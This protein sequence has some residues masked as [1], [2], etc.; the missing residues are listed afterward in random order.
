VT[1]VTGSSKITDTVQSATGATFEL[2][3]GSS[4][5]VSVTVR[6]V[7][8]IGPGSTRDVTLTVSSVNHPGVKPDVVKVSTVIA[9]IDCAPQ[10]VAFDNIKLSGN[11]VLTTDLGYVSNQPM[12]VNGL[13]FTFPAGA[14]GIVYKS[15]AWVIPK[16]ATQ[17]VPW[18]RSAH[19]VMSFKDATLYDGP[20]DM[21]MGG[22]GSTTLAALG[23]KGSLNGLSIE[24][25]AKLLVAFPPDKAG[26]VSLELPLLPPPLFA[27][28]NSAPQVITTDADGGGSVPLTMTWPQL[29]YSTIGMVDFKATYDPA[30][31][32]WTGFGR[33]GFPGG[34]YF[35][36][37]TAVMKF[38]GSSEGYQL[39]YLFG[40][41]S[42]GSAEPQVAPL[43]TLKQLEAMYDQANGVFYG[44]A[45]F[46]ALPI[47]SALNA[48]PGSKLASL[49]GT[50]FG[51]DGKFAYLDGPHT[52]TLQG[53][54]SLLGLL[55]LGDASFTAGPTGM[56]ATG[57]LNYTLDL[58]PLGVA[59]LTGRVDGGISYSSGFQIQGTGNVVIGGANVGSLSLILSNKGA[60]G[61]GSV[62]GAAA[63][64][65]FNWGS[66]PTIF[67]S[68]DLSPWQ[69]DGI[70]AHA[71]F[72]AIQGQISAMLNKV[73]DVQ[74]LMGAL[75]GAVKQQLGL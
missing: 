7:G 42:F 69:V 19:T 74:R 70:P 25:G 56:R 43:I 4:A 5:D 23:A 31:D 28:R 8:Q 24:P 13:H 59:G 9:Q 58:G 16:Y 22:S 46:N 15:Q 44:K 33:M 20:L 67:G 54:V 37:I 57:N 10:T 48:E 38:T 49:P 41:L 45:S 63:G 64:F 2:A 1:L 11:C 73:D 39:T 6:P 30:T 61:C 75:P 21:R 51:L 18:F 72:S 60:A 3:P 62:F 17:Y 29:T 36:A 66:T 35:P 26:K 34:L 71:D 65:G 47:A 55:N 52:M 14:A 40:R 68:C 53:T 12:D 32:S 27:Q 50:V